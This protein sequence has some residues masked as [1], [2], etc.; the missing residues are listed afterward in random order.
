MLFVDGFYSQ[1]EVSGKTYC[2]GRIF[3]AAGQA[4]GNHSVE[5]VGRVI[6][7]TEDN[8]AHKCMG[9]DVSGIGVLSMWKTDDIFDHPPNCTIEGAEGHISVNR[10][11]VW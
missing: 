9:H 5:E 2:S 4:S 1:L 6:E 3:E 7:S 8:A 11:H 10:F